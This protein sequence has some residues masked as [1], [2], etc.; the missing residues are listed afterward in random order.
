MSSVCKD[1]ATEV[2]PHFHKTLALNLRVNK[3]A[4]SLFSKIISFMIFYVFYD[5]GYDFG[6]VF[7]YGS[8]KPYFFIYVFFVICGMFFLISGMIFL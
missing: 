1:C 6:Y 5:L 4:K 7:F 3:S 8:G 2:F